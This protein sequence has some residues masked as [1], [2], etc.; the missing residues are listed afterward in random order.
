MLI[1]VEKTVMGDIVF[2]GGLRID[3]TVKGNIYATPSHAA[4]PVI[5]E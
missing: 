4:T 3:G 2:T 1:G 5:S